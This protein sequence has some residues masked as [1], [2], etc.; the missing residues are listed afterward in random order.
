[1]GLIVLP[2]SL[3]IMIPSLVNTIIDLFKDTTLVFIVGL[4][5]VLNMIVTASRN[6]EWVGFETEGHVFAAIIFWPS[7]FLCLNIVKT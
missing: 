7:A 3:K 1:M 4:F 6:S 5:D 2:Q